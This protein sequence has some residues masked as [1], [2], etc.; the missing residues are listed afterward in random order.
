MPD[1]VSI[2]PGAGAKIASREVGWSGETA[3][4]QV[5]A[6]GTT[7]GADDARTAREIGTD[8]PLPV[9]EAGSVTS[10]LY[11]ILQR[12]MSPAGFDTSTNRVRGS[13]VLDGTNNINNVGG[14]T[15]V[16]SVSDLAAI[17]T[18]SGRAVAMAQI[19]GTFETALRS[20]IG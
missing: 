15:T 17:G 10:L 6:L 3:Q 13:V 8:N 14:V 2:T 7:E 18:V 9:R 11:R 12:L 16:S 4:M 5:V 1:N 19:N 20:R